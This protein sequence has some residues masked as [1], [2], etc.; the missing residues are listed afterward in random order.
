MKPIVLGSFLLAAW[1]LLSSPA[2]SA[3]RACFC[4]VPDVPK[5]VERASAVFVGEVVDIVEPVTTDDAATLPG[6]LFTI[7][8]KVEE[9][10]K[11]VTTQEMNI[12]SAQGR[13]GCFAYPPVEKGEKYLVYADEVYDHGAYRK[14]WLFI[15]TCNRTARI[16]VLSTSIVD[17]FRVPEFNRNDGTED[18]KAL[19]RLLKPYP[20]PEPIIHERVFIPPR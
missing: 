20:K 7:K 15:S 5:A 4:G 3:G 19:D 1:A 12:L 10:W 2:A 11:G 16:P 17:R 8:F 14:D 6:K 13:Y 9:A 18:L